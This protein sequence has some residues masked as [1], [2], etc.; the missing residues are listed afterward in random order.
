MSAPAAVY[1]GVPFLGL[2]YFDEEHEH[3][4]F[5]REEQLRD[6]L[7]KLKDSRFVTVIGSSG[8]GKSSLARAGLIPALRAGFFV[9]AGHY[10][11]I[12]KTRPGSSPVH[13]LAQSMED[14]FDAKGVEIT[15]RR[16]PL[17]LI[18]AARQCGI[19]ARDNLLI[20]VDQ[21]EEIFRYQREAK[22]RQAAAEESSS[23]IKLLLEATAQTER[24]IF[25]LITMRSDYLGACAQFRDLPERIN[26]GLYLIPRMRRDQ[27]EEAITGPAAVAGANFSPPLVQRLLND[28]GE[29]PDQL[30]VLQ[31]ALL[32][33]WLNWKRDEKNSLE[34]NFGHY[35]ATGGVRDGLDN[36]AEEIFGN[37]SIAEKRIAEVLFRCLTE[38]DPSN[39]DIRRPCLLREVAEVGGLNVDDVRRVAD[40]FRGEGVSFL[41]PTAPA[42]VDENTLLDITHESLIRK[43]YRLRGTREQKGWVQDEAELRE[44]YRELAKRARRALAKGGVLTGGDLD[45]ALEWRKHAL[46]SSWALRYDPA[47]DTFG[48]V[49]EYIERSETSRQREKTR[50]KRNVILKGAAVVLLLILAAVYQAHNEKERD[51]ANLARARENERAKVLLEQANDSKQLANKATASADRAKEEEARAKEF[52]RLATARQLVSQVDELRNRDSRVEV[53]ALLAI[54]SLKRSPLPD[55]IQAVREPIALLHRPL[56]T[57]PVGKANSKDESDDDLDTL[58]F[59]RG[60][61]RLQF[62]GDSQYLARVSED[63]KLHIYRGENGAEVMIPPLPHNTYADSL[64][65][66]GNQLFVLAS[67]DSQGSKATVFAIGLGGE[68]PKEV[69]A[70]PCSPTC[71]LSPDGKYLMTTEEDGTTG[72]LYPLSG[73]ETIPIAKGDSILRVAR[74][75]QFL[76]RQ[77]DGPSGHLSLSDVQG[78]LVG[79]VE[80]GSS[81]QVFDLLETPEYATFVGQNRVVSIYRLMPKFELAG[82]ITSPLE[83]SEVAL[84]RDGH[85]IAVGDG[86]GGVRVVDWATQA[87][88]GAWSNSSSVSTIAFAP[89]GKSVASLDKSGELRVYPLQGDPRPPEPSGHAAPTTGNE[90]RLRLTSRLKSYS[91]TFDSSERFLLIGPPPYFGRLLDSSRGTEVKLSANEASM[92]SVSQDGHY[93]AALSREGSVEI[94]DLITG[95][96]KPLEFLR[97][98]RVGWLALSPSAKYLAFQETWVRG[99]P[100]PM[101]MRVVDLSTGSFFNLPGDI[102][103]ALFS[104]DGRLLFVRP[105]EPGITMFKCGSWIV[106]HE[107]NLEWQAVAPLFSP[108]GKFLF[109]RAGGRTSTAK[110]QPAQNYLLVDTESFRERALNLPRVA[111]L[112]AARF[113]PNAHL[114][115]IAATGP[116]D[117]SVRIF[118]LPSGRLLTRISTDLAVSSIVFSH[119]S[120]YLALS[121]TDPVPR[122]FDLSSGGEVS[123]VGLEEKERLLAFH[124]SQDDR[125]IVIVS[126][127]PV[128]NQAS[129]DRPPEVT[130][131]R[132]SL[133]ANDLI[134]E[135]CAHVSRNLTED[136]WK[137]YLPDY[138]YDPNYLTCL[139]LPAPSKQ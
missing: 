8:T 102:V 105:K 18:E 30:P 14:V 74:N 72:H 135:G 95:S 12:A 28:A 44:Q 131:K 33:A 79:K 68:A 111:S 130:I 103:S 4:F 120:R 62:S 97:D 67:G 82:Q 137:H 125:A 94:I 39:N 81:R 117:S 58:I 35:D 69:L 64:A 114:L 3:L 26:K 11:R 127:F 48:I 27:L 36:H 75:A 76:L 121:S 45:A 100:R 96:T 116:N 78:R 110:K 60:S 123:R 73:G 122:I 126:T 106:A 83:P 25:V 104:P 91:A 119:S 80:G 70:K 112:S 23:F 53:S 47:A 15:L 40:A 134:R 124:F 50:R 115:A 107:W 88:I 98:V 139:E 71:L 38:R 13:N 9:A 17:G 66:D 99:K 10:W 55:A 87:R 32:R 46:K 43:W 136:E 133:F 113:S 16:G 21:F 109:V 93:A 129:A 108:D 90:L 34:I 51:G 41:T 19:G 49:T 52:Q 59:E 22:N 31:H 61:P 86:E 1:K 42:E 56:W 24:A 57:K 2:H 6:L 92:I 5:G 89:D 138:P 77:A 132:Q 37:L 85:F 84:S 128:T 118:E 29:D 20:M 63:A 7:S 65:W 101:P 54:E